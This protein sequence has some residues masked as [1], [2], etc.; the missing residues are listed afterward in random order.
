MDKKVRVRYAPSP[1]GF[2][3][4]GNAQS[5]LFN[6]L[7]ARHFGGTMVLRIE[8][9]DLARNVEHG[10][11][12]QMKY[13]HWLGIDWDE[14]P[15]KPNP[16]YAPYH[17]TER[18]EKGIYKK[19]IDQLISEG[20]AY[21]DYATEE[22]L[23]QMREE[24][25]ANGEAPHYDGRWYHAS[26]EDIA[27]AKAKGIKPSVRFHLPKNHTYEWNDW[28][29]GKVEFN[30]DNL[31]GDFIIEKN[32]GMPTYNFAVVVDDHLM[33]ITDT[34]RGADHIAN[35][36]KQM[37]IYE[38]LGWDHPHFC[39]I[40]LIFNP[41]TGKKLSKR[42]KNTLQF[43]SEYHREG[44]LKEAIFNFIAFL[45]WSPK[46]EQE[47]Y[48]KDALI[49]AYDPHRMSKSPAFFDQKKL[50]W[51]N[52]QYIK[53]TD[54]DDLVNRIMELIHEQETDI[55]KKLNSLG[56][57]DDQMKEVI[58]R[59]VHVHQHDVNKLTEIMEH[60]YF[61]A[62]VLDHD[63]DYGG[64]KDFDHDDT[65]KVLE[66]LKDAV[67]DQPDDTDPQTYLN[68]IKQVGKD[69]DVK[70]RN[71]YFPLNITFYGHSSAPQINEI[72]AIYH[73]ATIVKLLDKAIA[74]L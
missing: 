18:N 24:Q 42:D 11:E 56:Y 43:I 62:T 17:Q 49:R 46:G 67:K 4:I 57:S 39:H 44:Y 51:I 31:G 45:G 29:L 2:L 40:S 3:H 69:V 26:E 55:A 28:A 5:A 52:A 8:D 7:F 38:A 48:S 20:K 27:A 58:L 25:K 21:Y 14:G 23:Q 65:L 30:S 54:V 22:E 10:E 68:L 19:Y 6:Y 60:A 61:Y 73:P 41:A 33:E 63:M 36:P 70:G 59:T 64:L 16:K 50:D 15:D 66:G 34:L 9:T 32:N 53:K 71:L 72:M 12:S 37:A 13:L 1:T 74:A 35:T 47:I